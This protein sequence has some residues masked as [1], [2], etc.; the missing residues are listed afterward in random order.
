MERW[1]SRTG[2]SGSMAGS[3]TCGTTDDESVSSAGLARETRVM[4][5]EEPR[6]G[7]P[8]GSLDW[9][10]IL[11]FEAAAASDRLGWEGLEA[12]RCRAEPAFERNV[13]AITH[14]RL[15]LVTPPPEDPDLPDEGGKPHRP[16]PPRPLSVTPAGRPA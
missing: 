6:G 7:D 13:P 3:R 14:H 12:A 1:D 10:E 11:P 4:R 16:A 8:I 15:V 9:L 5:Q 2:P